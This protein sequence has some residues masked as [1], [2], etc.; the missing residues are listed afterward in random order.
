MKTK[1]AV[2]YG[3]N[4]FEH[5]V[6]K[7]T[8]ES[9][10]QNIDRDLFDV[11]EVYIDRGG[12][13]DEH[14]LDS[15]DVAFIAMHGPN[16]EDGKFQKYLEDRKIKYTGPG[17]EASRINMDKVEMHDVHKKADL[18][19]VE[20]KGFRQGQEK[21]VTTYCNEIGYPVFVKPNNTG[22]SVG[23]SKVESESDVPA[24]LSA[25]FECDDGIC[26]EKGVSSHRE[27]EVAILGNGE[28]LIVT[29]PGEVLAH[30]EFYSYETKYIKP[31]ETTT[32]VP[33]MTAE[34]AKE[35]KDL[36]K[37][38]YTSTGCKGYARIDFLA[39]GDGKIYISE[40]STLPGFTKISM[41]PKLM[42]AEGYSYK[43]LITRIIEL[44]ME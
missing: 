25:A 23:I 26:V 2:I 36:A 13:F 19:V 33:D 12:K 24:A 5:E 7:M 15:I 17:V 29:N 6:S 20:N 9:I 30:G 39:D 16:C 21:E 44:A 14:L 43:D 42:L 41:F 10:L 35:I 27:Y 28:D 11:S 22:S 38:A 18:P 8:A 1:V 37:L 31:F 40:V 34:K 32:I 4:S 3:G